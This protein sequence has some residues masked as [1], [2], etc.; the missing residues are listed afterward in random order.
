MQT[1]LAAARKSLASE[2]ATGQHARHDAF[3]YESED[4]TSMGSRTPRTPGGVSTPLK[5]SSSLSEF[6]TGREANGSMNKV[7]SLAKEFEQQRQTFDDD[8]KALLEVTTGQ[9]GNM[10]SYEELRK[11][12]HRFEGWKK[13]YKVRLRE[14]KVR[15]HKLG[16]S[17]MEKSRRKWWGKLSSKA[18]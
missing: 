6:G 3:G 8:A 10:N 15:L 13:E 14:T 7:S 5:Y 16:N 4:A 9:N 12:K 18:L 2:I 1:S 17:E 11:L